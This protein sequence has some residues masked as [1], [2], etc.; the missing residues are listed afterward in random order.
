MT[1]NLIFLQRANRKS[2]D[3]IDMLRAPPDVI[4]STLDTNNPSDHQQVKINTNT[5]DNLFGVPDKIVIPERYVP[6][7]VRLNI[8]IMQCNRF[9]C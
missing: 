1:C 9:K 4:Q 6:D 2:L 7:L 3:D 8:F 5:I